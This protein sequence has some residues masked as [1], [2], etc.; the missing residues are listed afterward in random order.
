MRPFRLAASLACAAL[1]V[2]CSAAQFAYNRLD[3]IAR[4]ELGKYVDMDKAQRAR[5][6]ADFRTFWDWHRRSELPRYAAALRRIAARVDTPPDDAE[7]ERWADEYGALWTPALE[8]LMPV[9]CPLGAS[10]G[11]AQVKSLLEQADDDLRDY[12]E[13]A[14]DAPEDALRDK[15]ERSLR[16]SLGHWLGELRPAQK[17]MVH[18]WNA[19]RPWVAGP[20]LA[21]RQ[22]WRDA[23]AATLAQ[24]GAADFCARLTPLVTAGDRLWTA[25]QRRAFAA[26]RERWLQLFAQLAPTL[27]AAQREHLRQRLLELAEQLEALSRSPGAAAT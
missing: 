7:L 1:V 9:L 27:D 10:L 22:R 21:F 25:E 12:A 14:V 20:W 5:F 18:D 6:D 24:R 4:W 8:H 17:Q 11:A 3:F 23:L 15:A 13:E 16:K 26:N 2:A 19:T